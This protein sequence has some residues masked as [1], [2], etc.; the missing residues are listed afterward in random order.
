MIFRISV[1][2]ILFNIC[3]FSQQIVMFKAPPGNISLPSVLA[4]ENGVPKSTGLGIIETKW[5]TSSDPAAE[6]MLES[7]SASSESGIKKIIGDILV[8]A[9]ISGEN[10]ARLKINFKSTGIE[11]RGID[12]N[13]VVFHEDFSVK[14]Q[15][16]NLFLVTRLFRTGNAVLEITE[17]GTSEFNPDT[18]NALSEGLRF[19]N[20]TETIV[21]NRMVVEI[22][23]LVFAYE[24]QPLS[25]E[26][27]NDKEIYI[28]MYYDV[29]IGINS[30]SGMTVTEGGKNEFYCSVRTKFSD[31]PVGFKISDT[32][33]KFSFRAGNKE[34]YTLK[35]IEA[36]GNKIKFLLSGFSVNFP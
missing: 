22:Q 31:N 25:I 36:G 7:F 27:I 33:Q 2:I 18:K 23:N 5:T 29:D 17:S 19:G 9:N 11:E 30:I 26:R 13:D 28:P 6:S 10:I 1:T 20:K 24:Y 21:E 35:Y 34:S 16:D 3:L 8:K 14:Y 12:K 4:D 32:D 15:A